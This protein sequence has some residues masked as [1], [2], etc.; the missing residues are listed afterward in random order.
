LRECNPGWKILAPDLSGDREGWVVA[1]LTGDPQGDGEGDQV[2]GVL[3]VA[4]GDLSD[5]LD[6]IH[7]GVGVNREPS[8]GLGEVETAGDEGLG[9][10]PINLPKV[11]SAS[12]SDSG[13][14]RDT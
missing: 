14:E 10:L 8:G 6:P 11:L 5:A 3:E 13:L 7:H 12:R 9:G 4:A 2:L 1:E